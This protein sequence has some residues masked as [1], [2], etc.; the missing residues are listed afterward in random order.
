MT[1]RLALAASAACGIFALGWFF[2][3]SS[4]ARAQ[5]RHRG[6]EEEEEEKGTAVEEGGGSPWEE[7]DD[8][9]E[10]IDR[11]EMDRK[12]LPLRRLRKA[13]T[14]IMRRTSRVII[15]LERTTYTHNYSAVMRTAEAMGVQ[16]VWVV[17][18]P[19]EDDPFAGGVTGHQKKRK[20]KESD[21]QAEKDRA[22]EEE[23]HNRFAK[24]AVGHLWIREFDTTA[25]CVAALREE[26]R[27]LWVTD[28]SQAAESLYSPT[29]SAKGGVGVPKKLALA[30]G[31]E[32]TGASPTLLRAADKRVYLPLNGF[33]DSLNLSVAA[34]MI[35]QRV[36]AMCGPSVVGDMD[37]GD[38][39]R[40]REEW[41]PQL[42]KNPE[43]KLEYTRMIDHPPK[44]L[45]DLRVVNE[46]RRLPR[47]QTVA[48]Q[49][50]LG[51]AYEVGIGH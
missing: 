6:E 17:M 13:E 15:V 31:T 10:E 38:R 51:D 11:N 26:G 12:D 23:E 16:N 24:R 48:K 41:Y 44:P 7:D 34:A 28:L 36:L 47:K 49:K 22:R 27:T 14:V 20:E 33:A 4:R 3:D 19:S 21:V 2:G 37:E 40:L 45:S 39:R 46:E 18:P 1:T 43:Q 5:R 35:T 30:F 29:L 9:I 32:S 50:E 8:F 42:A 25:A